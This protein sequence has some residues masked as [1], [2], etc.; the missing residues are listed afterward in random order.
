MFLACGYSDYYKKG[1]KKK[2][3]VIAILKFFNEVQ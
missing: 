1:R 2:S 3:K